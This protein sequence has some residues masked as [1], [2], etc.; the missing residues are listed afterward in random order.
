MT[1]TKRLHLHD[2]AQALTPPNG[3][4][5]SNPLDTPPA[6]LLVRTVDAEL[7]NRAFDHPIGGRRD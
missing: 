1:L 3:P 5:I 7:P 4:L 2:T 6:A